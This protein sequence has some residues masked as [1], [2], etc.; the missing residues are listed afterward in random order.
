MVVDA[1]CGEGRDTLFLLSEGY[2]V[3]ALDVCQRNL[4]VVRQK[5]KR[6]GMFSDTFACCVA[7]LAEAI[8]LESHAVDVVLDVWVLGSVILSLDGRDGA[9]RFLAEAY[10]VLKPGGLFLSQF[11]T[12]RPRRSAD[13]LSIY[14]AN[15]TKSRFSI[16][17]SEPI[18]A[19]YPSYFDVPVVTRTRW[20]ALF[21]VARKE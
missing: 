10:R 5:T 7:D 16:A 18:E 12:L 2:R 15:L 11:E 17:T 19:D 1:G 9:N 20:P 3:V 13:R 8:P 4:E 21:V 6:A 14:F